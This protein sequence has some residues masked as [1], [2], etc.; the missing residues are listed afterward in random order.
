MRRSNW[1]IFCCALRYAALVAL[2][3][4]TKPLLADTT[5]NS[6]TTTVSTNRD[7]GGDLYVATT[8]I[9]TM[10]VVAGGYATNDFGYIGELAGS[11]GTVDVSSGTW[12]SS[13]HLRIGE[14][15]TGTLTVSGGLVTSRICYMGNNLGSVATVNVSSG[16]WATNGDLNIGYGG[17]GTLNVSGGLVT[18]T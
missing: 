11:R 3:V 17:T 7:F 8:G 14:S 1:T 5:L 2:S 9:A 18:N 6:G 16:T 10:N 12:A 4:P 15:G 13:S